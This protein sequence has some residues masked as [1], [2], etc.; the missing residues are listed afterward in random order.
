MELFADEFL[1]CPDE[2]PSLLLR[3][4]AL[5][6]PQI[7]KILS[8]ETSHFHTGRRRLEETQNRREIECRI[9]ETPVCN[10]ISTV[11]TYL[12]FLAV[13]LDYAKGIKFLRD[14]NRMHGDISASNL[15]VYDGDFADEKLAE[16]NAVKVLAILS[17]YK[18]RKR[19]ILI[20]FDYASLIENPGITSAA[21][22]GGQ[23]GTAPFMA[24]HL[25]MNPQANHCVGHDL[26]SL[27]YVLIYF[28]S[29]CKPGDN[30]P[31][32][33]SRWFLPSITL[34]GLG[35]VKA[36]QFYLYFEQ[37]ILSHVQ[38]TFSH[39]VPYLREMWQALHP[40]FNDEGPP[41]DCCEE[42]ICILENA[43][44][45]SEA[46]N[47]EVQ[48]TTPEHNINIA[49]PLKEDRHYCGAEP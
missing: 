43:I 38:S 31:R 2:S 21:G 41:Q 29:G 39:L 4:E 33:I 23:T 13:F 15:M 6:S 22:F 45:S 37:Q 19:G 36:A 8:P 18:I 11:N 32:P 46:G 1:S 12:E 40:T 25:L 7:H 3:A 42:L 35:E 24:I 26:E 30:H 10:P 5:Q 34:M 20:D 28:V 14:N 48:F 44:I 27:F 17:K 49:K 9:V 47:L 16:G